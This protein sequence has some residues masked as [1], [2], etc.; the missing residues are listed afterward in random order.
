MPRTLRRRPRGYTCEGGRRSLPLSDFVAALEVEGDDDPPYL[1][2]EDPLP[3]LR[4]AYRH[5]ELFDSEFFPWYTK[6]GTPLEP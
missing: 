4:R 2:Q 3:G 5:P 6:T 1:F